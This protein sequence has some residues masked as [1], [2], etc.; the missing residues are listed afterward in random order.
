VNILLG[1]TGSIAAYKSLE[2]I[3][4]L[5]KQGADVKVI[6]TKSGA[7]FVTPL[8]CQILST[9]EVYQDQ[10][11]FTR[12]IKHLALSE[13]ADILTIAPA[14]ANI[15]GKAASGIGDD[16][17]STTILSFQKPIL[18]IP[19]MDEGMWQNKIVKKNVR[20]L[21]NAGHFIM[22]PSSGPLAS[23]KIG[24]GRFPEIKLIYKKILSL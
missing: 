14:T 13:W 1:I 18:F 7:H 10:F 16:L 11:V 2:L 21:K 15:I 17:L 23:G 22:E 3:R 20:E 12:G 8:S 19:T 9:N 24:K 5:C 6:L 4:L